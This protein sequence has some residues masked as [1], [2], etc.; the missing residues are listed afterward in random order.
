MFRERIYRLVLAIGALSLPAVAAL[1]AHNAYHQVVDGVSVYFGI[2]PAELV[3]GHPADHPESTMHGGPAIGDN[4]MV[5][6]L[7]DDKTRQ[8]LTNVVVIA[9]VTGDAKLDLRKPLEPM[10]MAGAASYGNYFNM[11]GTGPYRIEIEIAIPGKA[12][13]VRATFTWARS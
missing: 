7:F 6:A 2:V 1:G 3:R 11:T 12:K 4:H 5:V 9:R 10:T 8:R 13:P